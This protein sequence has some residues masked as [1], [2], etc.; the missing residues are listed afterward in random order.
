MQAVAFAAALL[1]GE[2]DAVRIADN[3]IRAAE[4]PGSSTARRGSPT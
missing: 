4:Q 3:Q 1:V 2:A